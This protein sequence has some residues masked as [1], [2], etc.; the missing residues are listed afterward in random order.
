MANEDHQISPDHLLKVVQRR[1]QREGRGHFKIFLGMAAG[2]GKTFAML[3]RAHQLKKDGV[4]VVVGWVE[5]HGRRDTAQL[6]EGLEVFPRRRVEHK[7]IVLEALD[8]DRLLIRRPKVLL[9]DELAHTNAP[10][11]RHAKRFQDVQELLSA[12]IDIYTTVNIQ[13]L[14]SRVD[15]IRSI[16]GVTVRETV[17]D[18]VLDEADEIILIDLPPEELLQRLKDGRIYPLDRA[19]VAEKHFF[20]P[21]NLT[22]LRELALRTAAGRVDRELREFKTLHGIDAAWKSSSRLMVAVFASPYSES[23]IRWTRQLAD[24]AGGSWVGVYIDTGRPLSELEKALL[25]KNTTLVRKLGGE[26][27][28]IRESDLV[29]GLLKIA[30]QQHVTQIVMGKSQRLGLGN[31]LRGGSLVSRMLRRSGD[32]DIYAVTPDEGDPRDLAKLKG[33]IQF[34]VLFPWGETGW[35]TGTFFS[36]WMLA[37]ILSPVVGYQSVGIV[38]LMAV[39][40]A[41]LVFSRISVLVL[42]VSLSLVHNFFFIPPLH[43][44]SIREPQDVLMHLMYFLAAFS[45][46]HLTT[47]L[48]RQNKIIEEREERAVQLFN[49]A[50]SLSEAK[51]ASETMRVGIG[52]VNRIFYGDAVIIEYEKSGKPTVAPQSQYFPDAKELAVAEWVWQ[53][54]S[55]AGR[56]TDTL[57]SSASIFFPLLSRKEVV[58]VLG[59]KVLPEVFLDYDQRNFAQ[60]IAEQIAGGLERERLHESTQKLFLLEQTEKLYRSLFDSVSHELKTPLTTIQGAAEVITDSLGSRPELIS[61]LAQQVTSETDR[62]L[63]VVDNMLDMTRLDSGTL[64]PKIFTYDLADILGPALQNIETVRES[65]IITVN[66]APGLQSIRCDAPLVVQALQNILHNAVVHTPTDGQIQVLVRDVEGQQVEIQVRDNGA[67]LPKDNPSIVFDRFYRGR[68]ERSGGVGLGLSIAKG[69][70][71]VQGGTL[72]AANHPDGGALFSMRLPSEK[73]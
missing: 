70:V 52:A 41:G 40:V 28:T 61:E 3:Q 36:V 13:H 29:S 31:L 19:H 7:D 17:P 15:T 5:T 8:I 68:P 1:E 34:S 4:D 22:A 73:V 33:G 20:Q 42:A 48:R 66:V 57:P 56:F 54:S 53:N 65:R 43:T 45:I 2:V 55:P 63:S 69:F 47:R 37:G 6:L 71:E 51:G 16:T 39:L 38:F 72:S 11:S 49:L 24:N 12:G 35:L 23:L 21:G 58:G 50:H 14:E 46:G 25:E 9:V 32:I 27:A 26:F 62:L 18:S 59:L 67:G 64:T 60:V 30:R 10:K 44:F